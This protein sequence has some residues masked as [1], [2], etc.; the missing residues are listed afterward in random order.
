M[1]ADE[2]EEKRKG[3][4][5]EQNEV[6]IENRI[7]QKIEVVEEGMVVKDKDY[8]LIGRSKIVK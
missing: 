6:E 3:D 8:T 1:V 7:V 5:E 2:V 4:E